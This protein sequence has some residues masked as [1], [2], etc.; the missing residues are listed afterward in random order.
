M[1]MAR[2]FLK[3]L[4]WPVCTQ[5]THLIMCMTLLESKSVCYILTTMA[6]LKKSVH[7]W[8][9]D[10]ILSIDAKDDVSSPCMDRLFKNCALHVYCAYIGLMMTAV[11]QWKLVSRY[12]MTLISFM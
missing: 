10:I 9:T 12:K 8:A 6:D 4:L 2:P 5:Y 7:T 11:W 1:G 3:S